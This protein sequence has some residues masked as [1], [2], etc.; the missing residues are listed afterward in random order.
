MPYRTDDDRYSGDAVMD[1][2]DSVA[3]IMTIANSHAG[4]ATAAISAGALI[5]G[6]TIGQLN[7]YL[8]TVAYVVSI[9][10]GSCAIFYYLSRKK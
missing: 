5:F 9:I 4:S 1:N 7:Q 6:L 10:S 3:H 2:P 8:Q